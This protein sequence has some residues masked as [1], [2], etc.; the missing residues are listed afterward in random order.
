[1]K[2]SRN[3]KVRTEY[4]YVIG[5]DEVGRGPIAGPITV[6]AVL[7]P[8]SHTMKKYKGLRD[9][10]QLRE[11]QREEWY[12]RVCN[13]GIVWATASVSAS[14]IDRIGISAAARRAAARAIAS[15]IKKSQ[16]STQ[17]VFVKADYGLFAPVSFPQVQI[18]KGDEK[19][20]SIALA[21]IMAKVTRDRYMIRLSK[22]FPQY[23]FGRHK[24]YGTK[25]HTTRVLKHGISTEHRASFLRKGTLGL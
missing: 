10:K 19:E 18:I 17:S 20:P 5:I 25:M 3:G 1:M 8:F 9:S 4:R 11:K 15:L 16:V 12:A 2:K 22:I 21:S 13:M 23:E 24:G 14:E 6:G 7:L